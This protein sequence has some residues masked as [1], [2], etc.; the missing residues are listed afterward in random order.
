MSYVWQEPQVKV[1]GNK[2]SSISHYLKAWIK[3]GDTIVCG[4]I[5]E[6]ASADLQA[7]WDSPFEQNN[8]GSHFSTVG[9]LLQLNTDLSSKTL[10][11]S[12]QIW[13]GN[14]P[15]SINLPLVLY[16]IGDPLNEVEEAINS[17]KEFYSPEVN[18]VSPIGNP[19]AGGFNAGR[20]PSPIILNMGRN[21]IYKNMLITSISEPYDVLKDSNGHRLEAT[22]NLTLETDRMLNRSEIRSTSGL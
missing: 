4:V 12:A 18:S 19:F 21:F 3:Q 13:S 17:I 2:D 10:L 8:P 15:V 7:N 22:I 1:V 9:G 20:I 16:A 11:N 6:G 14:R 5:G